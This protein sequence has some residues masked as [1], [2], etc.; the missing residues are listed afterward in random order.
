MTFFSLVFFSGLAL[1]SCVG[2][3]L[4]I[5]YARQEAILDIPNERSSHM[6]PT[7]GAEE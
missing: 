7:P 1:L 5:N 3:K 4:Y 2:T 6:L